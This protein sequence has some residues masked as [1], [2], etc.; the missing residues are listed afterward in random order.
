[1]LGN[2]GHFRKVYTVISEHLLYTGDWMVF[3]LLYYVFDSVMHTNDYQLTN[4]INNSQVSKDD[5]FV[6]ICVC[7]FI[8]TKN[9]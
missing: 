2:V 5:S 9:K 6:C 4:N 7:K 1:M 3:R 8:E